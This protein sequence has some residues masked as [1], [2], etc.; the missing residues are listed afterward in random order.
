VTAAKAYY[1]DDDLIGVMSIDVLVQS[2]VDMVNRVEVGDTG[3]AVIFDD[4]GKFVAHPDAN[5]IGEDQS[6]KSFYKQMA[7]G[8]DEGVIEF[9][10]AGQET[11]L[12]YVK[13]PM[14]GWTI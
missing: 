6:E 2:L 5:M 11:I 9:E 7:A 10:S 13:N 4:E 8:E 12:G 3:F 1:N 14:T